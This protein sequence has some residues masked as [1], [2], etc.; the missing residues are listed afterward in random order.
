M[1]E[2]RRYTGRIKTNEDLDNLIE[3][4]NII[5]FINAQAGLEG[6][7]YGRRDLPRWSR[8]TFYPQKL[9]LT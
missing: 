4:K 9:T 1:T 3:H 6:R 8:G 7:E 5:H 2:E